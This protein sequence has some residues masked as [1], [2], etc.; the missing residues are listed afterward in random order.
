LAE[1]RALFDA[2]RPKLERSDIVFEFLDIMQRARILPSPLGALQSMFIRAGVDITPG[3]VRDILGLDSR[4]GL[5]S[6]ERHVVG[7][8]G[9]LADRIPVPSSPAVQ[10]CRR[11]GLPSGW[12]YRRV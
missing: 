4:H 1:L 11:L 3:W 9:A 12:L 5:A 10:A 6:W 8:L 7:A 2:M